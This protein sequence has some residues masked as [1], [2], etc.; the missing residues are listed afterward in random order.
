MTLN[1]ERPYFRNGLVRCH[2]SWTT[3]LYESSSSL[4]SPPAPSSLVPSSSSSSGDNKDNK[5]AVTWYPIDC[6]NDDDVTGD[7]D[8][9]KDDDEEESRNSTMNDDD[10]ADDDKNIFISY[11]N[12][13]KDFTGKHEA[14][15]TDDDGNNNNSNN[16]NYDDDTIYDDDDDDGGRHLQWQSV[17]SIS[18]DNNFTIYDL[19]FNCRYH[20]I[21]RSISGQS[22]TSGKDAI[23]SGNDVISVPSCREIFVQGTLK[24]ICPKK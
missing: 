11:E 23:T 21:V 2:V 15:T 6:S 10:D 19:Q 16:N 4:P 12:I 24:P 22:A 18:E 3:S 7:D 9:V 8:D 13:F 5:Y 20:V 14:K 1:F 17:S